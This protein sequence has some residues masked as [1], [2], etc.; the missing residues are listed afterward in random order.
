MGH[1][2]ELRLPYAEIFVVHERLMIVYLL[3]RVL[4]RARYGRVNPAASLVPYWCLLILY[5][6]L[7]R[8][9]ERKKC[10]KLL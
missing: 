5:H 9:V 4:G 3:V 2:F 7:E 1:L 10:L 8:P 6:I